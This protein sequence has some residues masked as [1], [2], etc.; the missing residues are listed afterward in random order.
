MAGRVDRLKARIKNMG[1]GTKKVGMNV[2]RAGEVLVAGSGVAYLEGRM[3][4]DQGEWGFRNVP[5]A[6]I[7]GGILLLSGLYT[8]AVYWRTDYGADLMSLGVGAVGGHLFRTMYESGVTAK[9][10]RTTGGRAVRGRVGM[11]GLNGRV[12]NAAAPPVQRQTFGTIFDGAE[13]AR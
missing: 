3:S 4:N 2:L 12:H 13:V 10:N 11:A 7:G 9:A 5:F 6:Y 1:E 8:S